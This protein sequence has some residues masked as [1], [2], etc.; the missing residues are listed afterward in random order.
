M[1]R[2]K[3]IETALAWSGRVGAIST[4]TPEEWR[5]QVP[6]ELLVVERRAGLHQVVHRP[7]GREPEGEADVAELEVE[8]DQDD[9]RV[10]LGERDREIRRDER[11]PGAA[12]R[13]EDGD[14]RGSRL[15]GNRKSLLSRDDLLEC[16]GDLLRRLRK[17]DHVVGA[18]FERLPEEAVG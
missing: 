9:V 13:S 4:L 6:V 18:R 7:L 16:E 2:R 8:V 3:S 5:D 14:D 15:T 11:L 10:A 1:S 17:R 12:L